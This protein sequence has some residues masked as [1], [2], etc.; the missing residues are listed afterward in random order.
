MI[1][2]R[3]RRPPLPL[4]CPYFTCKGVLNLSLG[5]RDN[6]YLKTLHNTPDKRWIA[7]CNLCDEEWHCCHFRCGKLE[8]IRPDG[9]SNIVRHEKGR[10]NRHQRIISLPCANN[11][12]YDELIKMYAEKK[13]N[14]TRISD[15]GKSD[16]DKV[17]LVDNKNKQMAKEEEPTREE[18]GSKFFNI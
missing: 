11:P 15:I 10:I 16:D 9:S 7:K 6:K 13:T 2:D 12:K 18:L 17:T 14:I 3:Y 4:K 8:R 1:T 5:E